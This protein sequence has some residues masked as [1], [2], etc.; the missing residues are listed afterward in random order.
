MKF[1]LLVIL[2]FLSIGCASTGD[3][4]SLKPGM[5]EYQVT[6]YLGNPNS[7]SSMGDGK[8][9]QTYNLKTVPLGWQIVLTYPT[10]GLIYLF[11]TNYVVEFDENNNLVSY[12]ELE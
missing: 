6:S 2:L 10:L 5:P 11:H 12:H 8:H 4:K 3:L 9:C 1:K 7:Y